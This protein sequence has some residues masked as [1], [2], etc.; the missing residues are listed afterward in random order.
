MTPTLKDDFIAFFERLTPK[1]PA[2]D[3]AV[4][5]LK[6]RDIKNTDQDKA[7]CADTLMRFCAGQFGG[8]KPTLTK[9]DWKRIKALEKNHYTSG[10]RL[11]AQHKSR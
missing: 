1:S 2:I 10:H 5:K 7:A 8:V 4:A 3:K 9:D 6:T 11:S